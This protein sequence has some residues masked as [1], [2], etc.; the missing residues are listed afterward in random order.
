M[1]VRVKMPLSATTTTPSG[2]RGASRSVTAR[3]VVE[4]AQVAVVD[5]DHARARVERDGEL[6]LVVHLDQRAQPERLGALAQRDELAGRER[7]GDQQHGVAPAT[8]AS[9]I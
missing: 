9:S 2:T 7:G 1:S 4:R 6:Q 3:S 5:A 8:R